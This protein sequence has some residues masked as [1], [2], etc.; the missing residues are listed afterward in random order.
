MQP[1]TRTCPPTSTATPP[2]GRS[3]L[4]FRLPL[5][6]LAAVAALLL[7]SAAQ[8]FAA[9]SLKVNLAGTGTGE[10]T[11]TSEEFVFFET[12]P[13][14]E[15][16]NVVGQ[17]KT[18]CETEPQLRAENEEEP[19]Y[20]AH[21]L[22]SPGPGSQFAGWT[23]QK[24]APQNDG[25][26]NRCPSPADPLD[27][28]VISATEGAE[29]LEVTASFAPIP[30]ELTLFVNGPA[31][32]GTVTSAPAGINCAAGQECSSAF[33]GAIVLTAHPATGYALA[34]WI[35]CKQA[36]ATTCTVVPTTENEQHEATAVFIKEGAQG[37]QGAP[38]AG[39]AAGAPGPKGDA[40]AQGPAGAAGPQGPAGPKGTVTCKVKQAGGKKAKV[41]CN[42]KYGASASSSSLRWHLDRAGH[43]VRHGRMGG[44]DG[45][46]EL[47]NLSDGRYR[48][49]VQGRLGST[50]IEVA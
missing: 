16:S 23:I 32:S 4:G 50:L 42:V 49:H 47:G 9:P 3:R 40:G 46:L 30:S 33:S 21:L 2:A 18:V 29:E 19:F 28:Q 37:S 25:V 39:G 45:R 35:G 17:V 8:A 22:A 44:A 48:L 43:S 41:T 13:P 34:G 15:C 20:A 14:V 7:V 36:S 10:V 26:N 6:L 38:G 12:E 27:C 11:S 31:G 1:H 5:L 24:G